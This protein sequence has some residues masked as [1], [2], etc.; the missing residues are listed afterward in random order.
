MR[1]GQ[2]RRAGLHY[3]LTI[4]FALFDRGFA[5]W[6]PK[7]LT[8]VMGMRITCAPPGESRE[9]GVRGRRRHGR[10]VAVSAVAML[11]DK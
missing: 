11:F 6:V 2:A 3:A 5:F 1:S 8:S 9:A 7:R 10:R 4:R